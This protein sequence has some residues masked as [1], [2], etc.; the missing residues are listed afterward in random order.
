M[1]FLLPE[2]ALYLYKSTIHPWME[3]CCHIWAANPSCDLVLLDKLQ[4]WM[5]STV[6]PSLA[7]SHKPLAHC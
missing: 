6:G 3:Y 5:F 2:V 1:K 4:K 7:T